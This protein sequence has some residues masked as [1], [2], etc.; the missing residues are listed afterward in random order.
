MI[1]KKEIEIPIYRSFFIIMFTDEDNVCVRD[2]YNREDNQM[3][4]YAHYMLVEHEDKDGYLIAFHC[5]SKEAKLTYGTIIHEI[6]HAASFLL[7]DRGLNL[8]PDSN[9]AFAYLINWLS[10]MVFQF[11][12][13]NHL[14]GKLFLEKN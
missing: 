5:K 9:E 4:E 12:E 1:L 8:S 6:F 7:Y 11:I 10:D 3:I 14:W 2:H 13:D